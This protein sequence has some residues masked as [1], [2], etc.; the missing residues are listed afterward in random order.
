MPSYDE[1]DLLK[2]PTRD[3]DLDRA[4]NHHVGELQNRIATT[5]R[6]NMVRLLEAGASP[7]ENRPQALLGFCMLSRSILRRYGKETLF[8]CLGRSP[9]PIAAW[10]MSHTP[11]VCILPFSSARLAGNAATAQESARAGTHFRNVL[12]P[13]VQN[14][15][16][17]TSIVLIDYSTSGESLLTTYRLVY[18]FLIARYAPLVN[19]RVRLRAL[20]IWARKNTH[21]AAAPQFDHH[22][23][24]LNLTS[25]ATQSWTDWFLGRRALIEHLYL[26]EAIEDQ[27]GFA[28]TYTTRLSQPV[29][30]A[31]FRGMM[32]MLD[33]Q[34]FDFL[35]PYARAPIL[36]NPSPRNY[37]TADGWSRFLRLQQDLQ[38]AEAQHAELQDLV[39]RAYDHRPL[40]VDPPNRR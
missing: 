15:G 25:A 21:E 5:P 37:M 29:R 26:H 6:R 14:A 16:G 23:Q 7:L 40:R 28:F 17:I 18:D 31:M 4:T 19:G 30:A 12:L 38:E 32:D 2:K 1:L 8:V 35:S 13:Y 20:S 36:V 9:T 3:L 34:S 33:N 39:F 24:R 11:R 10:L 27:F 22:V